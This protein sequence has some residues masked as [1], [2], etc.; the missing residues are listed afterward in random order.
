M[1]G[2]FCNKNHVSHVK[3]RYYTARLPLEAN[4]PWF[5]RQFEPIAF[6]TQPLYSYPTILVSSRLSVVHSNRQEERSQRLSMV[7]YT[8]GTATSIQIKYYSAPSSG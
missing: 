8:T 1:F 7:W 4:H 2:R 3:F 5:M 6:I